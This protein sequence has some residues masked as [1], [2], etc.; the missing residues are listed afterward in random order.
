[1]KKSDSL[2]WAPGSDGHL[3][4][5]SFLPPETVDMV[6][7]YGNDFPPDL[8]LDVDMT[9][10][11]SDMR[12]F[13]ALSET[14]APRDVYAAIN[15]SLA[16]QTRLVL[17]HGGSVNKFLGD[18][19][20][21]CFSGDDRGEKAV[22]CVLEML[23]RLSERCPEVDMPDCP[24]GFGI[25]EG[26]VLLGLLGTAERKEFTV[27]GDVVNTAARLCGMA[28]PF[29]ALITEDGLRMVPRSLVEEHCRFFRSVTFKGKSTVTDVYHIVASTD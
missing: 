20:L 29:Q 22:T 12:G 4:I 9:V 15:A 13:T 18:G 17:A 6:M 27:I 2:Q 19:L 5:T 1:M 21:A 24:V 14:Y 3:P 28:S 23:D 10:L 25:S 11:F 7:K 26:R 16:V 8:A